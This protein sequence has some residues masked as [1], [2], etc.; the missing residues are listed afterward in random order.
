[1]W[2]LKKRVGKEL[3]FKPTKHAIRVMGMESDNRV[4]E[5]QGTCRGAVG[6]LRGGVV[7]VGCAWRRGKVCE[8]G[9]QLESLALHAWLVKMWRGLSLIGLMD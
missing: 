3:A 6:W 1:M 8:G 9:V 4:A 2:G 7:G 5:N